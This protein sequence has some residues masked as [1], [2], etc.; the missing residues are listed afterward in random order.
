[1]EPQGGSPEQGLA[2][3]QRAALTRERADREFRLARRYESL[4]A[5][6]GDEMHIRLGKLHRSTANR[7]RVASQLLA[8]HARRAARWLQMGGPPPLFMAG[9]AEACGTDSVAV[10]L[11]DA[12]CNQLAAASSD[13]FSRA[14]QDLE[15]VLGEGPARD[16]VFS[17]GPVVAS[18]QA[19]NSRWPGYG[20]AVEALGI[21]QVVAVPMVSAGECIGSLAAFDGHDRDGSSSLVTQVADA[22]TRS[23]FLGKDAVPGLFGGLDFRAEVHQAAGMVAVQLGCRV[24]DALELVKARAFADDRDI[25]EVARDIVAGQLRLG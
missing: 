20:P 7:H 19:L 21:G 8:G 3:W 11:V 12:Q 10:T 4:A 24:V 22:L 17:R 6:S 14:A 23:V 25:G 15:F 1:M 18:G 5:R 9:V 16:S 13:Q 2:A